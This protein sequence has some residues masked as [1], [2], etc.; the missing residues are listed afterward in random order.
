MLLTNNYYRITNKVY[1]FIS[2]ENFY[3]KNCC[4]VIVVI[5]KLVNIEM[6][7]GLKISEFI[8]FYQNVQYLNISCLFIN[9]LLDRFINSRVYLAINYSDENDK[10]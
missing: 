2:E 3:L 4:S 6:Y 10:A 8:L 9:V 5:L 7:R 1:K